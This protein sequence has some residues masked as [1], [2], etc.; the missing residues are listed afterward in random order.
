M[1]RTVVIVAVMTG[2][3]GSITPHAASYSPAPQLPLDRPLIMKNVLDPSTAFL[4]LPSLAHVV[5]PTGVRELR[6]S[7]GHGMV[8]GAEYPLIRIVEG[9]IGVIGEVIRFRGNT[10]ARG[11]TPAT[12][13]WTSRIVTPTEHI[14]WNKALATLDSLGIDTFI[15]PTYSVA[16]MDAGD[17]TVEVRRGSSYRAYEVN[18]P[19]ARGDSISARAAKMAGFVHLLERLTRG[20]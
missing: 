20:Y 4:G 9:P 10:S 19:Q 16:I 17:L 8:L 14:D 11:S 1:L 2:C 5:L 7:I 13:R 18:A 3:G 12:V 15:S 6:L